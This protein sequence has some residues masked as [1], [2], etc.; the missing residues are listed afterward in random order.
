[1][2][3]SV[4]KSTRYDSHR[5]GETTAVELQTA[6]CAWREGVARPLRTFLKAPS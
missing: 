3:L 6:L 2:T 4:A 1:M 5:S